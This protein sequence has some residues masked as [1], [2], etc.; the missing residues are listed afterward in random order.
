MPENNDF[1]ADMAEQ[2]FAQ[3]IQPVR[4]PAPPWDPL[5]NITRLSA[6]IPLLDRPPAHPDPKEFAARLNRISMSKQ[7][8][9]AGERCS[10]CNCTYGSHNIETKK[11]VCE[12][13]DGFI[14]QAQINRARF[15]DFL[16]WSKRWLKAHRSRNADK[17]HELWSQFREL[18]YLNY[19]PSCRAS[20]FIHNAKNFV[21]RQDGLTCNR[22]K[23]CAKCCK[24]VTC[25]HCNKYFPAA[26][27]C[28]ECHNCKLNKCCKCMIC[29]LC[30]KQ[31]G[32]D[33][34]NGCE[35]C[36]HCCECG[37]VRRVP[38]IAP[39]RPTF[40]RPNIKQKIINPLSRF[41][42]T[43]IEVA[44]IRGHGRPIYDIVKKWG[45]AVVYDG[46]LPPGGFEI[47]TAPAGGDL[48]IRQVRE[49]CGVIIA[50]GGFVNQKC[51]LHVHVD[52]RDLTYYDIRRLVRIYAAIEYALF[53]MVPEDRQLSRYCKP[54]GGKYVLAIEEGRLP[55]EK[56]KQDV[57]TSVYDVASTQ[58]LRKT[59]YYHA[60]YNALN[61]HS[62]FYRGT[63]ECRM[64]DGSIDPDIINHWCVL[65]STIMEYVV[66]TSDEQV[67]NDMGSGKALVCLTT[68]VGNNKNIFDFINNR[69]MLHGSSAM[70]RVM[71][72]II[73]NQTNSKK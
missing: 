73:D 66:H 38:L 54:C 57:I 69:V 14:T 29:P 24:C 26:E 37:D 2:G 9:R 4:L 59:K 71:Q 36:N 50:E 31:C 15:T 52:A 19:C 22:C 55:Y 44:G 51:G 39:P 42:A 48:F 47:N 35:R 62:W 53:A 46:S 63:I 21:K 20:T 11:C 25:E 8:P 23:K 68:L 33:H 28:A 40:H 32:Y 58:D 70:K 60:R 12:G 3:V 72:S 6:A 27:L 64:F 34:C 30:N 43:E 17:L 41:I 10:H 18:S 56:V 5:Q 16:K 61:L 7:K 1:F 45:G 67:K 13:C 49:I 65:W